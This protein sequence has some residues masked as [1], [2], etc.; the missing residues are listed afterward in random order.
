[1]QWVSLW[2]NACRKPGNMRAILHFC[3]LPKNKAAMGYLTDTAWAI[4]VN[5]PVN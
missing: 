5:R 3:D 1:M 4:M 2:M